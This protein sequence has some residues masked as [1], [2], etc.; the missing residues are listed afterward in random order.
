MI[1][2]SALFP[3]TLAATLSAQQPP[4]RDTPA[5][6]ATQ[7]TGTADPRTRRRRGHGQSDPARNRHAVADAARNVRTVRSRGGCR[8]GSCP[9]DRTRNRRRFGAGHH[10]QRRAAAESRPGRDDPTAK[11]DDGS[12]GRVRIHRSAGGCLPAGG[13]RRTVRPAVLVDRI[14]RGPPEWAGLVRSGTTDRDRRRAGV[15]QGNDRAAAR[16]RD[17]RTS[18]GRRRHAARARAGVRAVLRSREPSCPEVRKRQ[19][20]RPRTVPDV[21]AAAGRVSGPGRDARLFISITMS[22]PR[23]GRTSRR[24]HRPRATRTASVFCRRSIRAPP[25]KGPRNGCGRAPAAKHPASRFGCSR[26]ACF[27]FLDS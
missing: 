18:D 3:L 9:G 8:L 25:T 22:S 15:R 27:T 24:M 2:W 20:R 7:P 16:G 26:D 12:A 10:D 11:R 1:R 17:L 14:R 6:P 4:P 23:S 13:V 21:R 19:H 5:R